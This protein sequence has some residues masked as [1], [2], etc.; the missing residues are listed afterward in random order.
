MFPVTGH[1]NLAVGQK[2]QEIYWGLHVHPCCRK[3]LAAGGR[4]VMH[5]WVWRL[6]AWGLSSGVLV[7]RWHLDAA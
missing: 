7:V 6:R 2:V 1:T 5:R 3:G 4:A